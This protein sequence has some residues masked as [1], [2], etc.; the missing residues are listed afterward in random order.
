MT[1]WRDFLA[2][3]RIS[4]IQLTSSCSSPSMAI[5]S[6]HAKLPFWRVIIIE[7]LANF[8]SITSDGV[9]ALDK[10]IHAR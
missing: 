4:S 10:A 7:G 8:S 3:R 5:N 1:Y 2:T 6:R 9:G